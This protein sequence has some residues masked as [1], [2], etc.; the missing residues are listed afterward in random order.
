MMSSVIPEL[1]EDPTSN[2]P[3]NGLPLQLLFWTLI[4]PLSGGQNPVANAKLAVDVLRY[5][6]ENGRIP[7][8]K[9]KG[10]LF[11]NDANVEAKEAV[12]KELAWTARGSTTRNA[13]D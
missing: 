5:Y 13:L 2:N 8:S 10:G 1:R 7:L 6:I 4:S 12:G 11:I 3:D 9:Y